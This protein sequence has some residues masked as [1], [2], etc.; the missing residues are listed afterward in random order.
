MDIVLGLIGLLV[1]TVVSLRRWLLRREIPLRQAI[2]FDGELYRVGKGVI[3]RRHCSDPQMSVIVMPGFMENFLYFTEYYADPSIELIL[4]TSSDYHLPVNRPRFAEPAWARPGKASPGSIAADAEMLNLA[5]K[6][7]VRTDKVRVH[8]HSRGGA[9]VLEAAR[10]RPDLFE[11]VEVV[12]EAP[13]LPQGKPCMP[14]SPLMLWAT[15]LLLPLWQQQPINPRNR[16]LWGP[17]DNPRKRE[18]IMGTPFTPRNAAIILTN[19]RDMHSWMQNTGT[20]IYRHVRRGAILVPHSDRILD[21][22]AMLDSAQQAEN[23][24]V[25]EI[26][27]GSHFIIP[28]HPDSIPPIAA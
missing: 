17:L 11:A 28:D 4:L 25:I 13:M 22:Q 10:L 19:L 5:L 14:S 26:T 23:L 8:G 6:H 24:Q 16:S 20:D 7:L 27:G 12:L 2:D 15:P 21:P 1:L 18:L 9:V 3:A